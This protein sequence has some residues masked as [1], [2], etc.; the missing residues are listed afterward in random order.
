MKITPPQARALIDAQLGRPPQ[1]AL[2]AAVVLEAWGGLA[3]SSSLTLA[4]ATLAVPSTTP[5]ERPRLPLLAAAPPPNHALG[6][7]AVLVAFAAGFL[8]VALV[9]FTSSRGKV[10]TE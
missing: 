10:Y 3:S 8:L 7:I 5:H 4:D 1:D 9:G 2:E 6:L